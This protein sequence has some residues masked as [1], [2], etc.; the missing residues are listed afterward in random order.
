[1]ADTLLG[2]WFA[3]G[4]RG[5]IATAWAPAARTADGLCLRGALALPLG[6][7]L[8]FARGWALRGRRRVLGCEVQGRRLPGYAFYSV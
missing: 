1:M 2:I 7:R 8:Q 6:M 3:L 4:L 5:G